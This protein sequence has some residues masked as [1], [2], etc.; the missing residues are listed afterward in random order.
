MPQSI[1]APLAC[2]ELAGFAAAQAVC[3]LFDR[4]PYAP[5]EFTRSGPND[6]TVTM[7]PG[8]TPLQLS[9]RATGRRL[10]QVCV[11]ESC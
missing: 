4:V 5:M 3:C 11:D 6:V 9:V 8:S 7:T 1:S 10:W 2:T